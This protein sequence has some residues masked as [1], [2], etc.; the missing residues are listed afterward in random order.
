MRAALALLLAASPAAAWEFTPLPV[1]TLSHDTATASI[2]VTW[3]PSRDEAYAITL[4]R[5]DAPWPAR[6]V[7]SMRFDGPRG[8]TIS[9]G[10]HRLSDDGASL[11]VTDTGFG[12]VLDGLQF[13]E[14]ATAFV[15]GAEVALP[16]DGAAGPV[17]EFRTC[18]KGATA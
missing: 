6:D 3:D 16:L 15:D 10:R 11:T 2:A 12:N 4:T 5:R 1:C 18:T 13:N 7:L 17:E 8:L 14:M 9:T